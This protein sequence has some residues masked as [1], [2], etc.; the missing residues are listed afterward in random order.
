MAGFG[1]RMLRAIGGFAVVFLLCLA[2]RD[3]LL[4]IVQAPFAEALKN[5]VL[6]ADPS[7]VWLWTPL[8]AACY[9]AAPWISWQVWEFLSPRLEPH[10]TGGLTFV[11]WTTAP[12]IAGGLVA[13]FIVLPGFLTFLLSIHVE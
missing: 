2:F 12:L 6:V 9:C 8:V 4:K 13:Y 7:V 11:F 3:Q 5:A 1:G 10:R